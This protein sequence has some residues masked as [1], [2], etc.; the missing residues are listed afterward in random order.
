MTDTPDTNMSFTYA[1]KAEPTWQEAG[2]PAR[3]YA[4]SDNAAPLGGYPRAG[5]VD[6]AIFSTKPDWLPLASDMVALTP[7][8]WENRTAV[9]QIIKNGTVESY[10][11]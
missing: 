10:R 5:W 11:D 8:Q 7:Q 9:G 1:P 4:Y 6:V 2:Y 3:Y